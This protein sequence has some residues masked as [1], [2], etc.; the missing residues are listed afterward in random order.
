[1]SP[2]RTEPPV[3]WPTDVDALLKAYTGPPRN[4]EPID[5]LN[6]DPSLQPKQYYILGTHPDSTI[7]FTDVNIFDS[8]GREPFKGDVLIKGWSKIQLHIFIR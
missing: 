2:A 8:T 1:M 3:S 6:F 5:A 7:L 4:I